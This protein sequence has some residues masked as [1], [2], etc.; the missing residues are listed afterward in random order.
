LRLAAFE[1]TRDAATKVAEPGRRCEQI[2][3]AYTKLTAEDRTRGRDVRAASKDRLAA[4]SEGERCRA[5]IQK[6]D[7][8]FDSFERTVA[9]AETSRAPDAMKAAAGAGATLDDFDRSRSRYVSEAA[10]LVKAKEFG[11]AIAASDARIAALLGST[12]TFASDRSGTAHIR[13]AAA[14]RE[15]TDFDRSRLNPSERASFDIAN[16]AAATVSEGRGR[17][18]KLFPLVTAIEHGQTADKVR[19]LVEA[20]AAITPFDEEIATPEQKA[21]LEKARAI[22][23][24]LS[25]A[26]LQDRVNTLAQRESPENVQ[27]VVDIY[28]LVKNVPPADLN[29]QQRSALA[30]GQAATETMI[31]SDNRLGALLV[32]AD[33]WRQRTGAGGRGILAAMSAITPFDQARFQDQHKVAWA[34]LSRASAVILGPERGL[35]AATKAQVPIFVFS[36]GQSSLDRDVANA[37]RGGLRGRGF[38]IVNS[39]NDAALLV[40]VSIDRVDDPAMDT[41]GERISWK[42]TAHLALNAVWSVDDSALLSGPVQESGQ[43]QD[44]D[45]AKRVA[46]RAAVAAALRRFDQL[47]G[48]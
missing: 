4:L 1:A 18:A 45:E 43:D 16:R 11:A 39:R 13:L 3:A 34:A 26:L 24:P 28:R 42:V 47:T 36:S 30:M 27:S 23:K 19:T 6:S 20:T 15:L 38:Q 12:E 2:V 10:L 25:L 22:A 29:D 40:D 44:R 31:A 33:Q 35:T 8:H 14:V 46:L 21:T 48:N 9:A 17:L 41:S 5:N 7:Q 32:V 37:L